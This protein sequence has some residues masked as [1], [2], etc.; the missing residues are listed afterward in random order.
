MLFS[1]P[2]FHE[3]TQAIALGY[4]NH[5]PNFI[6]LSKPEF[7]YTDMKRELNNAD[8]QSLLGWELTKNII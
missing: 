2:E 8:F 4:A 6:F 3:E 5:Q 1:P 7:N